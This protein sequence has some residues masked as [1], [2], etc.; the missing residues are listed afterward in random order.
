MKRTLHGLLALVAVFLLNVPAAWAQVDRATLTGIVRD[1]S[2]AVIP[3]AQVTVTNIATGVVAKATTNNDGTYVVLNLLPGEYLVQA[4]MTGFQRFEQTV[5]LELGAR[6]RLDIS[7]PVGTIDEMV[8]VAGV[9]PLL[10]TESAALGTVVNNDEMS[11]LPLAIRNWDDLMAMVPGVQSDRYTEQAGG[12]SAG[13][14]GGVSVHGNRSLQNN[15]LLDG[16]A[17]NSFSTN[18]QELTTQISRPSVD[19]ISEFKVITSPYAAEYGWAPGASIVVNTKSGTN[20]I[21]GTGYDFFRNDKLDTINYFA[22]KAGQPKPTNKQNQFGGNLGGAVVKNR[23]FFFGDYEGTRIQ[24]GVLRTGTVMTPAQKA[25]VFSTAIRDPLT[26]LPFPNNTIPAS[27]IDPVAANIAALLPDPNTTGS[28]NFIRQPNVEDNSDRFL[29]R[30]DLHLSDND[31]VFARYIWSDRFRYVPGWFGGVLDGTST[32]AWGRNYLKSNGVVGGWTKVLGSSLVNEARISYARGTNDGTQDPFGEDGNAQIGL[33]GVPANPVVLGGVTGMDITGHIRIG[34]PNFMPKFQHTNQLQWIDTLSWVKG[35]HQVK[36]GADLMLPMSNEYFDVAPTRG[37]LSFTTQ[38]T[39]NAFADF[40]LGYVQRAQLTNVFVVTQQLRSQSFFGQDDWRIND[41]LTLNL[42]LRYDYMTPAVEKDNK[43]ANFDPAGAGALVFAKDGSIEDRALVNPD[44][45]NFAPRI[46]AVY[47]LSDRTIIRGGYGIFYN[48]FERIGSEDQLALNPPGLQ[49]IDITAPGSPN[50]TP[51]FFMRD[52]F[53]AGFLDP[54][55]IVLSRLLIRTSDRHNPRTI[56]Q[57]VGGGVEQQVGRDFVASV[58]VVG[59]TT[60]HLAVLRNLN[61]N[62]PGTRDA[63]GALPYPAFGNV[64]WREMT[65]EASYR[66][67]DLSFEKRMSKGYSY[68]ASYTVG[69]AIDQAPEHLNASSGRPQNGRDLA[70][71]EGPSDFDI[72]H[73]LVANFIAELPFG[74]GKPYLQEGAASKILGGWLVTGIYSA[75]SGRPMTITQGNNNVGAGMT[76]L[77]NLT[78]DPKGAETVEQWYNPAAFTQVPSGMFG[79]AGRNILRG[80]GWVT[81]DMSVQRRINFN[82]R[83]NA[84]VRWDIFNMFNRANFGLPQ[85]DITSATAGVISDLAGDPR[86]M[87]LSLRIGF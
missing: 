19:A 58:D 81:F 73:R 60:D 77:P 18:V 47:K 37:N 45:N 84:T 2:D 5:S 70:A 80:P 79:N 26:G 9:T 14:T 50:T 11:K 1:P 33:K 74:E 75:R 24:Q 65:G 39:G 22:K 52:G 7:L 40:M 87:Q 48:Q 38:F 25:G 28:N 59:S 17:N 53:P 78:G 20:A 64:Q 63:N 51:V 42:G 43:M 56:V 6:A 32:S 54:S 30:V 23:M 46:G 10:S 36:F 15:F 57:Q 62:L 8:T 3:Q 35:R 29:G 4:E 85:R 13:R 69:D 55:N 12:T 41:R 67:V 21:H 82:P 49:N 27:R 71:W 31:T 34:S 66:G 83:V 76:G 16:V 44:R 86:V 61:Q 68:R 72:R